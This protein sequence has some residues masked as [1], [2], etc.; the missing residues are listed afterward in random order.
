MSIKEEISKARASAT[1][2]AIRRGLDR[3]RSKV[4]GLD[5]V[6][7]AP[8]ELE[9]VLTKNGDASVLVLPV[10][11]QGNAPLEK[12]LIEEVRQ[13]L[14]D[15]DVQ[16]REIGEY[17]A[18]SV[19]TSEKKL[20]R[21]LDVDVGSLAFRIGIIRED[22]E[23]EGIPKK[24]DR[25]Y[26]KQ[27]QYQSLPQSDWYQPS[28]KRNGEFVIHSGTHSSEKYNL[29]SLARTHSGDAVDNF[30]GFHVPFEVRY[31]DDKETT[32]RVASPKKD[33]KVGENS[34]NQFFLNRLMKA[35]DELRT[36]SEYT[37][38]AVKPGGV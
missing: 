11:A 6:I 2:D 36:A 26:F 5:D 14:E 27:V 9:A 28:V 22:V 20:P 34:G 4:V 30:P 19:D 23:L 24:S 31:K 29:I 3:N 18:F 1:R 15:Y 17:A 12:S 10:Y 21:T 32:K 13:N 16:N 33:V 38:K 25:K 35:H 37:F 8:H 7:S